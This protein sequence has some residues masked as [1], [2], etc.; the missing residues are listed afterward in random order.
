MDAKQ[1][2]EALGACRASTAPRTKYTITIEEGD[3]S[4]WIHFDSV[5]C[6]LEQYVLKHTTS[7]SHQPVSID[8]SGGEVHGDREFRIITPVETPEQSNAV[9]YGVLHGLLELAHSHAIVPNAT[10]RRRWWRRIFT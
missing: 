10:A 6:A 1:S 7:L 3:Q 4:G 9:V 5:D 2:G 8:R